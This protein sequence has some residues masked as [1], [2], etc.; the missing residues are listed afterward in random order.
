MIQN[1]ILKKIKE[2][3]TIIIHGHI[4]PDGDCLGSQLGLKSIIKNTYK[5]KNVYVVGGKSEY[6]SFLGDVDQIDDQAFEGALS[7]IVDTANLDRVSD[8]RYN[9]SKEIIKIDHHIPVEDYGNYAWV[10]QV[11]SASEMIASLLLDFPKLKIDE[12]GATALYTGMVTDT[13]RFRFSGVNSNTMKT[14]GMLIDKGANPSE[15][16]GYLS[17]E[18]LNVI[19]LKGYVLSNFKMTKEGFAY[20]TISKDI[21]EQFMVSDEDASSMVSVIGNIEG[22]PVWALF[23]EYDNEI[24]IRLRSNGPRIDQLANKYN[25]G[26]HALASGASIASFD[27]VEAFASDVDELLKEW[28]K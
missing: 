22:F 27:D 25:G 12:A 17:K 4:R 24:R 20:A 19:R 16:D 21:K 23:I 3:D 1:K 13:G 28:N 2:Y 18:S 6:L 10:G 14:A 7:I 11:S 9:L 15:I 26:G 5:N 8:Q